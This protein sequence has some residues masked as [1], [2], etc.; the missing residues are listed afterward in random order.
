MTGKSQPQERFSTA[1][2]LETCDQSLFLPSG[3]F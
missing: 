3:Q 2:V 1:V